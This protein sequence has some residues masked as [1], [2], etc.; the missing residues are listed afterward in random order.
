MRGEVAVQFITVYSVEGRYLE[1]QF[2][3]NG[4]PRSK[5]FFEYGPDGFLVKI[6]SS[7]ARGDR[8]ELLVAPRR[9]TGQRGGDFTVGS[10]TDPEH[11]QRQTFDDRYNLTERTY[12]LSPKGFRQ[13]VYRYDQQREVESVAY[14]NGIE[15]SRWKTKYEDDSSGNWVVKQESVFQP[16]FPEFGY[17]P[18]A[19]EFRQINYY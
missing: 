12:P 16:S 19:D 14:N 15:T 18:A 11:F 7:D 6:T 10:P 9:T 3:D 1:K 4:I 5:V 13:F 17:Q 2:F 8:H